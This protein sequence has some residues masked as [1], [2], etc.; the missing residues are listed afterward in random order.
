MIGLLIFGPRLRSSSPLS[1]SRLFNRIDHNC[2]KKRLDLS[3]NAL[4]RLPVS[5]VSMTAL[6]ELSVNNNL[7]TGLP[8]LPGSSLRLLNVS[9]NRLSTFP[10]F[11][12]PDSSNGKIMASRNIVP[13][14][15]KMRLRVDIAKTPPSF[16]KLE[17]MSLSHNYLDQ[18]ESFQSKLILSLKNLRTL[19]IEPQ[20]RLED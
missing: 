16:Q 6:E 11:L 17:V 13:K 20:G 10:E 14:R 3:Y 2:V 7:L 1:P 18:M 5:I 4:Q 9:H 12:L 8:E 19:E 15:K